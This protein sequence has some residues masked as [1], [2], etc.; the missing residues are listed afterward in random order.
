MET[1]INAVILC[2]TEMPEDVSYTAQTMKK[3]CQILV[4]DAI[5]QLYLLILWGSMNGGEKVETGQLGTMDRL[6]HCQYAV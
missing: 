1:R 6:K 5:F 2:F 3:T 4:V